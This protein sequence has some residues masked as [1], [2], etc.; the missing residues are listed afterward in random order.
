MAL[1]QFTGAQL[2]VKNAAHLLRRAAFGA[3]KTQIDAFAG[4]SATEA[5]QQLYRTPLPEPTLPPDPQ[6]GQEWFISGTTGASS[7]EFRLGQYFQGWFISQMLS[8]GIDSSVALSYAARE[9]LVLFLHTHFT[10][11]A[12]K[13]QNSRALYFQNQLFRQ[14]CLDQNAADPEVN[15]K[16]L[17]VKTS[18]DNAMLRLLDGNLNVAGN[19]NE[20]YAR[21][22]LELYSIGRG[23]EGTV[24]EGLPER[25]YFVYT[26][27]DVMAAAEVLSGWR[28]DDTF[29]NIDPD[30]GL[31]RG[32]V[33]GTPSDA[34]SHKNT[35]K[36]FSDRFGG[37]SVTPDPALLNGTNATEESALDEIR[38]LIDIIYSSP[39]TT[40]NICWKIYRFF[41]YSPHDKYESGNIVERI[42]SQ[43]ITEMVDVFVSSGYKMQAV[44][45]NLLMSQHF[46]N[47]TDPELQDD[48]YGGIIKSPLDLVTGT[49]RSFNVQLPDM[50]TQ[51]EQFYE[52]T[53]SILYLMQSLGMK[54]YEPFDV[55]GYEAYHQFPIFQRIWITPG[56]LAIRYDFIRMLFRSVNPGMFYV[57]ALQYVQEN[58]SAVAAD[59]RQLIV[60]VALYHLPVTDN[61]SFDESAT[62]SPL[63]YR[64]LNYF[65]ERFL[66]NF[67][68]AYWTTRWNEG[69]GDLR[70]Q[71]EFLF[72]AILQTPEYQLA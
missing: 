26:E 30:T 5:V 2:G 43:I 58:F 68:E 36:V 15:F 21:E 50:S 7:E 57:D 56:A 10:C 19:P 9:R 31:P 12:N 59:A 14:F 67:D 11:I 33:R 72:N 1:A 4:L 13:V 63:T 69:A 55:A 70:E 54:F 41:V 24:P 49:F 27:D 29:S 60:A 61:L 64:R 71:L 3:T 34:S 48:S 52:S 23:L 42:D 45:E 25:D 37:Q 28:D 22:L 51:T 65:L 53:T 47:A 35:V 38:Q 39:L 8:S 32:V 40:R 6:T 62:D 16:T 18:V 44:I 46:Y 20:N 17:T 66:Q